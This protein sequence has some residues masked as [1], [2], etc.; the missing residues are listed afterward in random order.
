MW[1]LLVRLVAVGLSAHVLL[2]ASPQRSSHA[3]DHSRQPPMAAASLQPFVVNDLGNAEIFRSGAARGTV[4]AAVL[5]DGATI[6]AEPRVIQTAA[7][8][9]AAMLIVPATAAASPPA[10]ST[11]SAA[12]VP[13]TPVIEVLGAAAGGTSPAWGAW[14]AQQQQQQ[15]Q[16]QPQPPQEILLRRVVPAPVPLPKSLG[17]VPATAPG[18]QRVGAQQSP[19]VTAAPSIQASMISGVA[20]RSQAHSN[21]STATVDQELKHELKEDGDLLGDHMYKSLWWRFFTVWCACILVASA[22]ATVYTLHSRNSKPFLAAPLALVVTLMLSFC[23]G[24]TLYLGVLTL[25]DIVANI[26]T[27][28][29]HLI[30]EFTS[31]IGIDMLARLDEI[32]GKAG[33]PEG[34][35][36]TYE[37]SNP[38]KSHIVVD[39]LYSKITMKEND[40]A[41]VEMT[42]LPLALAPN[43]TGPLRVRIRL[44]TAS[45]VR[46]AYKEVTSSWTS[47]QVERTV[48][49]FSAEGYFRKK[50]YTFNAVANLPIQLKQ[51]PVLETWTATLT[52]GAAP[53]MAIVMG[54]KAISEDD[55]TM[56]DY[57][58]LEVR[59]WYMT[60][61]VLWLTLLALANAI[62][63]GL[64]FCTSCCLYT[65]LKDPPGSAGAAQGET[66][67]DGGGAQHSAPQQPD[68]NKVQASNEAAK[69]EDNSVKDNRPPPKPAVTK[70]PPADDDSDE[71]GV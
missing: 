40:V 25:I 59:G 31:N 66:A 32:E 20:G 9:P 47:D 18:S 50:S 61:L 48:F 58:T 44:K 1:P 34:V 67:H 45:A 4:A 43:G 23:L 64:C 11:A 51:L 15:Q 30:N 70:P 16:Q 7:T 3:G 8:V 5:P 29:T 6:R 10:G 56:L 36:R 55:E 49:T 19:T 46:D 37:V 21:L 52:D 27:I 35:V 2:A 57:E 24:M 65:H 62:V 39:R 28:D 68:S 69:N 42:E 38:T 63:A 60:S 33:S 13:M 12:A 26:D 22:A 53:K 14:P 54:L 71:D 17:E 41:V